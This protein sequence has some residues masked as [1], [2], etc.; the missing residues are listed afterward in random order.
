ML[1]K[2]KLGPELK[3]AFTQFCILLICLTAFSLV[4]IHNFSSPLIGS[5]G[6]ENYWEFTGYYLS[7]NI[8]FTPFPHLNL[9]NNQAFYPYG[10]N[11]VFQPWGFER[12][13]FYAILFSMFGIGGWI[14]IYYFLSVVATAVGTFC[15]LL[16]DYRLV[17]A[18]GAGLLIAFFSFYTLHKYPEHLS[19]ATVHWTVLSFIVDFLIVKRIVL[20]QH[21]SLRLM[22]IRSCLLVLSLSQELGYIAGFALMSFAVSVVY[23]ASIL[24][25]RYSKFRY[26]I[27]QVIQNLLQQYKADLS[28]SR[29][30]CLALLII[31]AAASYLYIP[32]VLQIAKAAKSIAPTSSNPSPYWTSPYR[33]LIPYLPGFNPGQSFNEVFKDVP[34][35]FGA[36]SPGWFLVIIGT[37]GLWQTRRKIA[38]FTPLILIFLLCL[39]Y[40]PVSFPTLQI[41]PWLSFARVPGRVSVIYPIILTIFALEL[42]VNKFRLSQR[43]VAALLVC[44]A[45]VEITTAYYLKPRFYRPVEIDKTFLSYMETVRKQPGEAVLDWPFCVTGGNG[46]GALDGLCP[47]YSAISSAFALRRFHDKK[48]VGQYFGRLYPSQFNAFLDA[49]WKQMFQPNSSNLFEATR[50]ARCFNSEEWSFFTNFY[51]LNDFSGINLYPDLLPEN[52]AEEFYQRFGKPVIET[53]LPTNQLRLQFISKPIALKKDNNSILGR[54]VK[55]QQKPDS[56]VFS[57]EIKVMEPPRSISSGDRFKLPVV[58]KNTS[59]EVWR[60]NG[61]QPI[62]F[63]YHW[64]NSDGKME[65]F[66]GERTNFPDAVAPG[67][68]IALNASIHSPIR[69]GRFILQLTLVQESVAWFEQRG[70]KSFNIPVVIQH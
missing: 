20:K 45:C 64:V 61:S 27:H 26:P 12:D 19:Y 53:R 28:R 21:V 56:N 2:I 69:A 4:F 57:F 55:L 22:L 49:G 37:V 65:I 44:L 39:F 34:E 25:Y 70:A 43:F 68:S 17:R 5:S 67:E 15:L 47:Y 48:V 52:C 35:G 24:L 62:N 63:S 38:V 40:F 46:V 59:D 8:Q 9:V 42:R 16:R 66:N 31:L 41:F 50:Q 54:T 51:Q 18:S 29:F 36:G 30:T 13:F 58:V 32:L 7:K 14:K 11:Q 60:S 10:V 1:S 3:F 33:L 23:I 6:D